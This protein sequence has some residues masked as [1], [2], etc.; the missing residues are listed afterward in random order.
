MYVTCSCYIQHHLC[1]STVA[2]GRSSVLTSEFKLDE[3]EKD[4]VITMYDQFLTFPIK[5]QYV[6]LV[7]TQFYNLDVH[8]V[9]KMMSSNRF[10]WTSFSF[11]GLIN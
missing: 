6:C 5:R 2:V 7:D 11:K 9:L 8:L 4:D 10:S 3:I 1:N